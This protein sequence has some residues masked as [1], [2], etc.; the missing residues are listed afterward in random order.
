M[1]YF[2]KQKNIWINRA[3]LAFFGPVDVRNISNQKDT[4]W[5]NIFP[6]WESCLL[7]SSPEKIQNE[8]VFQSERLF[9]ANQD[10]SFSFYQLNKE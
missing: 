9:Y 7:V 2:T 4:K 1:K 10:A 5:K 8:E 3:L 6:T